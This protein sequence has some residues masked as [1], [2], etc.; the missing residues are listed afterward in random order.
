MQLFGTLPGLQTRHKHHGTVSPGS[1]IVSGLDPEIPHCHFL[2]QSC[3]RL[4]KQQIP[5]R[6]HLSQTDT[7]LQIAGVENRTQ[8]LTREIREPRLAA[9]SWLGSDCCSWLERLSRLDVLPK[10]SLVIKPNLRPRFFIFKLGHRLNS[11]L[12]Q[13]G[14][15][16]FGNTSQQKRP[17]L[18]G[19]RHDCRRLDGVPLRL[20]N[21]NH[22]LQNCNML[23]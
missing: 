20:E 13:P 10:L 9:F 19:F 12:K 3:I 21:S 18:F 22:F 1:E 4:L 5:G 8:Q 16:P 17:H 15:T 2:F 11:V 23:L 7:R 6:I 14:F